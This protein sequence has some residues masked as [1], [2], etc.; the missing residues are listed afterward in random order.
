[1]GT[2]NY[3]H[4][5]E[6]DDTVHLRGWNDWGTQWPASNAMRTPVFAFSRFPGPGV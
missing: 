6:V 5:D 1:M 2:R 4:M 3:V